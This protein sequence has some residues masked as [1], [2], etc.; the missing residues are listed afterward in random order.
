MFFW[1]FQSYERC[2]PAGYFLKFQEFFKII[3]ISAYHS[4]ESVRLIPLG[5]GFDSRTDVTCGSSLSVVG[6]RPFSEGFFLG[7]PVFHPP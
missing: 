2:L 4:G 1:D 5:L 7:S 6:S 3:T